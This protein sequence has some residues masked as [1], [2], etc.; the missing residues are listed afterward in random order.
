MFNL[1]KKKEQEVTLTKDQIMQIQYN[2]IKDNYVRFMFEI[3]TCYNNPNDRYI[4]EEDFENATDFFVNLF[5]TYF[6]KEVLDV[7]TFNDY[8]NNVDG[9]KETFIREIQSNDNVRLIICEPT[10][11]GVVY[12]NRSTALAHFH[13]SD[14]V[15]QEAEYIFTLLKN[16]N[17]FNE[18]N[19]DSL[20]VGKDVEWAY[21]FFKAHKL[22]GINSELEKTVINFRKSCRI[23]E[24]YFQAVIYKM[25]L[26]EPNKDIAIRRAT[27]F[28]SYFGVPFNFTDLTQIDNDIKLTK[29]N[30]DKQ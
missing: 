28:A 13:I 7:D 11:N 23:R 2:N 14:K 5:D 18:H 4:L 6:G 22:L 21:E 15:I 30:V 19:Y 16:T 1:K 9:F 26:T 27:I 29:K 3:Y 17:F 8:L 12:V 20:F 10:V 25:L 24:D